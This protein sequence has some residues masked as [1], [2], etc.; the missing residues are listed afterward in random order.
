[1]CHDFNDLQ[2]QIADFVKKKNNKKR[3]KCANNCIV[4][5][6]CEAP[7]RFYTSAVYSPK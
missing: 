3:V 4:R 5:W 2:F 6:R 1:M 7:K